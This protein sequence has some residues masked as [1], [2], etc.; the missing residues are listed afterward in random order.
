MNGAKVRFGYWASCRLL[1]AL[2]ITSLVA[3]SV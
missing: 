3:S 2:P 1:L